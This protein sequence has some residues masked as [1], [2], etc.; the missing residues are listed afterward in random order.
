MVKGFELRIDICTLQSSLL[1]V[2]V[3]LEEKIC[4]VRVKELHPILTSHFIS[5]S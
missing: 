2:G 5:N 1:G 4:V 3:G